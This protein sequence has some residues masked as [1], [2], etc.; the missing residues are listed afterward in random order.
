M[1]TVNKNAI[2]IQNALYPDVN[3]NIEAQQCEYSGLLGFFLKSFIDE[4]DFIYCGIEFY[5]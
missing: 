5:T 1:S 4:A 3:I 2:V